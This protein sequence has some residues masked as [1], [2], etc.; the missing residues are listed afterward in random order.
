MCN[1]CE[2]SM[3][4]SDDNEETSQV[5]GY[6]TDGQRKNVKVVNCINAFHGYLE[7]IANDQA[8]AGN[9]EAKT[10]IITSLKDIDKL[11]RAV[12][13]PLMES[14]NDAIEAIILTMHNEAHFANEDDVVVTKISPYFRELK[15]FLHRA[16]NDFLHP[17]QCQQ[18]ISNCILPVTVKTIHLFVQHACMI[19]YVNLSNQYFS[20]NLSFSPPQPSY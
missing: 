11:S 1:K 17:F 15:N 16:C 3:A 12:I 18:H 13:N 10:I 4:S 9:S 2:E 14:I 7:K 19:R 8:E 6:P 5:V 20:K